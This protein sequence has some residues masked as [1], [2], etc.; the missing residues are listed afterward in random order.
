MCRHLQQLSGTY[1]WRPARFVAAD[2]VE[3]YAPATAVSHYWRAGRCV[4][5][6]PAKLQTLA[7]AFWT[8]LTP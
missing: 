4:Q 3:V 2:Y 5:V 7:A 1:L 8:S 6:V